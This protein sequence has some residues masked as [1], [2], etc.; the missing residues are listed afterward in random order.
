M[1]NKIL[2]TVLLLFICIGLQAQQTSPKMDK[3]ALKWQE[4]EKLENDDLPR[5]S[6][7]I[8]ETILKQAI[9]DKNTPQAIKSLIYKTKYNSVID[10]DTN[11][12]IFV[13]L[14]NLLDETPAITDK[15]VL[16]SMLGE[17]YLKYYQSKRWEIDRRTNMADFI[18]TD[19]KE[20]S[21]NIFTDKIT[22]HFSKA[23]ESKNIL[24]KT[25]V[26]AYDEILIQG[27]DSK[28][29]Y[30]T[31]YDFLMKRNIE[32]SQQ[33]YYGNLAGILSKAGLTVKDLTGNTEQF[34][35]ID[36]GKDPASNLF[37]LQNFQQYLTFLSQRKMYP[38]LI[39][40]ELSRN[41]YLT[42]RSE[43]YKTTYALSFLEGLEKRYTNEETS[44]FVLN[45]LV[46]YYNQKSIQYRY[47]PIAESNENTNNLKKAYE[48]CLYGINKFPNSKNIN[49][50]KSKLEDMEAPRAQLRF[51]RTYHPK[52]NKKELTLEYTNLKKV[53][54]K[55]YN[56]KDNSLVKTINQD[57][58]HN[59]TYQEETQ[60]IDLNLN[61]LGNYNLEISF[62]KEIEN[63]IENPVI[64]IT[65][66]IA[67][68]RLKAEN[69]FEFY[70]VDRQTGHPVK[71]ATVNIT[72]NNKSIKS[73]IT[74]D[75][76]FA[77][78]KSEKDLSNYTIR[79]SFEFK[80]SKDNDSPLVIYKFPFEYRFDE[81][82]SDNENQ[83][84][85]KINIFT[86]R[87]I[88][89]PGQTVFF[90]AIA[91][92]VNPDNSFA[93]ISNRKYTVKL[94][95]VNGQ[96]VSEKSLATNEF[97]SIA[98]EFVLPK[99]KLTGQ[100][101]INIENEN[102]YLNVEEYKRPTFQ[103][104]FDKITKTYSFGEK[105]TI[106]GH[107]ENFSGVKLQDAEVEYSIS[108]SSW[109]RW[110]GGDQFI[111]SNII[112]TDENGTFQ[113]TFTIPEN[114]SREV[115]YWR[116]I[117]SFSID[118]NVTDQNGETQ[119]GNFSFAVGKVSMVL[120][121]QLPDKV[122]KES[123]KDI[124]FSASNL[125]GES[126]ETSGSYSILKIGSDS[127]K[128]EVLKGS[129]STGKQENLAK[130]LKSLESGK[131]QLVLKAKDSKDLDVEAEQEFTLFSFEDKRPPIDTDEW[132]VVKNNTF[133]K[134]KNAEFILG[135]SKKE[136]T[137][138]YEL[139]KDHKVLE[140]QQIK[141]SNENH[142][143]VIPY[144]ESY[145][146]EV[147]ATYTYVV[148]GIIHT[149]TIL[150]NKEKEQENLTLKLDVFRDKLRPGDK[151]EWKI[152]VKDNKDK[153]VFAELLA[154]M[155]DSSL[156]KIY[157][158]QNWGIRTYIYRSSNIPRTFEE[159]L[160]YYNNSVYFNFPRK[161]IQYP[162]MSFD[163]LN[164]FDFDFANTMFMSRRMKATA[165]PSAVM[166]ESAVDIGEL[167]EHKV[168]AQEAGAGLGNVSAVIQ[169]NKSN[170]VVQVR[171]NF[172]ETAFFYP[173]LKTDANGETT[174][175]FT[176][177]ESN[178]TWKFRALA[179][180]KKLVSGGLE[181]LVV[182]RKELMVTPNMPRFLRQGDKA[183]ISTKISNLSE[184]S[185][186]G[187]VFIE[188]FDPITDEVLN[189]DIPHIEQSFSLA[190]DA[191]SSAE[192]AFNV[193]YNVDM[194]G[195]RIIAK[196]ENFSD[197][198]Q[199]ALTVLPNRMLV[200]ESMTMNVNG[201]QTK[202]FAF[203][204]LV[205]KKSQSLSNYRLTL[206]Y[207]SN[208]A[209]YAVQALPVISNPTNQN[210]VNW[211]A[212]YYA[213]T[214]GAFITKQYPNV[215]R[216]INAWQKQG[217]S[218]ETLIS[219]LEKNEELKIA[220]LEETPWVLDAKNE[221]EQM[222]RLSLL[223]DLNNNK[224]QIHSAVAKL[225]DLQNID[226]GWSWYKDFG[227]SRS[228]TQYILY[229]FTELVELNAVEYSQE[230]KEMQMSAIKY[231][232]SIILKDYKDLLKYTPKKDI[233]TI[234]TNQLEYLFVRS[235]YR[236]IPIDI[237][238]R[239]AERF[240]TTVVEKNWNK[241]N[242]YERALLTIISKR[243]GNND[244][245]SKLIKSLRERASTNE[246]M[247][248]FWAN[249][250]NNVFMSQSSVVT[251]TFL[252]NAFKETNASSKEMDNM[253]LWL[254]KQKQ[255]QV[256]EST[257]ATVDAIYALLSTGSDWFSNDSNVSIKVDDK[258]IN[259]SNKELGTG[260][261]KQTWEK[262]DMSSQMGNISITKAGNGPSFGAMY[263]QYFED[264]NKISKQ[265][266]ELNIDKKLFIERTSNDG[267]K[268]L[269][270]IT[271]NNS[272]KVGDK[273]VVRLTIRA[274]RDLEF[275][276]LKDMRASCFEPTETI[277]G[278]KWQNGLIYYQSTLDASTNYFFDNLPKGTY[279]LE[280]AVY[281]NRKG[282]YS[283]GI[284]SIQCLYAPEFISH[285]NG[286][287]VIVE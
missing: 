84:T 242:L 153:P 131:Y 116:N 69:E 94:F 1:N 46:N 78:Y 67:L 227:S 265:K 256:W 23:V 49:I 241:L 279:V 75:K 164:W 151:E 71:N 149:R 70:I 80:V 121:A 47:A 187:K 166:N 100:Y 287:S 62:D 192:W 87:N 152:S 197:G 19:I 7:D 13:A 178:T 11:I 53:Y 43:I 171:T 172:D 113:I 93:I 173:Q 263:W 34:L 248:M 240:Y 286:I 72:E 218:K 188:F 207:S 161:N 208:P 160:K 251:H 225:K 65:R 196:S 267:S 182:S 246:E 115:P 123:I 68:A 168:I 162:T 126:I 17:L 281:A 117:S 247:G 216:M 33:L 52:Q 236:D 177:P 124:I 10:S 59:N 195:C 40:T 150:I 181:E 213:N 156:D 108:K 42:N 63:K 252:M 132:I 270:Q 106:T 134:N 268:S 283:N 15:S 219:K 230:V 278:N 60:N 58:K 201:N 114:D 214:L 199:H 266:G 276:E 204:K 105:V 137:V 257:H 25:N 36:F 223:F 101:H 234:S 254:L 82:Q 112:Q 154:S 98:G 165:A 5:S 221:T 16:H 32:L 92:D 31:L 146:D 212:S 96:I 253:K 122:D 269:E 158:S 97:G 9:A 139:I 222:Q 48:W 110:S 27:K 133:S 280:Y 262:N 20:W 119:S 224:Q 245:A 4:V 232:D 271:E 202:D 282:M 205:N 61:E 175:S 120:N 130:Q 3:Y 73:L 24:E 272:L 26:N 38:T 136:T 273:V 2:T 250:N 167:R 142:K 148:D 179:Y 85:E 244:L 41:N 55:I 57:L 235:A 37:T 39:L 284:T 76:G 209:W 91:F 183:Y 90:K 231:I 22:H 6:L 79:N 239:D 14:E 157:H 186:S 258:P 144:K 111:E 141:I 264:L 83:K 243:N 44:I 176:V 215:S 249:N 103:I 99:G 28:L 12:E 184:N 56:A 191:S 30:P 81:Y 285:T 74:D 255:T 169:D 8:V 128:K 260:Y 135:L 226:G 89:R 163:Q 140:R 193:P 190:K 109:W 54:V 210:A 229:G 277:S 233:T 147:Y 145:N 228:I 198:E 88:Y 21:S 129:F 206:E 86:D 35:N 50:L 155:Y 180:D 261:I 203:E 237:E 275:V 189:I 104:T 127:I 220:L 64:S 95:D 200:T 45:D 259:I 159:N 138:L 66:L 217:G 77:S 125:N 118:A 170:E 174:I 274:D 211:F 18:P 185:I 51:E 194:I 29:Y 102:T 143:F 107:A 238:T